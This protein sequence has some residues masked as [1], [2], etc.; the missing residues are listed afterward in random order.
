MPDF[1]LCSSYKVLDLCNS[2]VRNPEVTKP[3]DKRQS[4]SS[5]PVTNSSCCGYVPIEVEPDTTTL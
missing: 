2:C 5:F 1:T 4:W 3:S